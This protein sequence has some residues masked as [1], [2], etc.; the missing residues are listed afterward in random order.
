MPVAYECAD[1]DMSMFC[2]PHGLGLLTKAEPN[3]L[4]DMDQA[5]ILKDS[6]GKAIR[7][8]NF[9]SLGIMAYL[10]NDRAGNVHLFFMCLRTCTRLTFDWLCTFV[11]GRC[12]QLCKCRRHRPETLRL[13]DEWRTRCGVACMQ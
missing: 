5:P 7:P 3:S 4:S 9:L 12:K 2:S 6:G 13:E 8:F 1:E 11:T 10:G